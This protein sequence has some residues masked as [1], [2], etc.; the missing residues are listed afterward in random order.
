MKQGQGVVMSPMRRTSPESWK[1]LV[2]KVSHM[3]AEQLPSFTASRRFWNEPFTCSGCGPQRVASHRS[4]AHRI[5]LLFCFCNNQ[6]HHKKG[7]KAN[8]NEAH[9]TPAIWSNGMGSSAA[10]PTV[11]KARACVRAYREGD[12]LLH[13]PAAVVGEHAGHQVRARGEPR[14]AKGRPAQLLRSAGEGNA[15]AQQRD[16]GAIHD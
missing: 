3:K 16:S 1:G 14:D 13:V 8:T 4:A 7:R 9:Y 11:K 6:P 10:H 5:G 15:R 12:V 2:V